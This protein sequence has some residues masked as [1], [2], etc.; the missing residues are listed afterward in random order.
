MSSGEKI[1]EGLKEAIASAAKPRIRVNARYFHAALVAVSKEETRF[2]MGGVY[3]QPHPE[4]GA[5]LVATDGHRL[6]CIHDEDAIC[7]KSAI[8]PADV[9]MRRALAE[10]GKK[11]APD[12]FVIIDEPGV[13]TIAGHYQSN[14]P[15]L[16]DGVYPKWEL[17]VLPV[18]DQ[19]KKSEPYAASTYNPEYLG[20]FKVASERLGLT[21]TPSIRIF[22]RGEA[23]PALIQFPTFPNAF[24]LLM[25]MSQGGDMDG[26]PSWMKPV[27]EPP[28]TPKKP[29]TR[30]GYCRRLR[31]EGIRVIEVEKGVGI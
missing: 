11:G 7:T 6:I 18:R 12:K 15:A 2:Y 20:A 27:L 17:V 9:S 5:L 8:V 4:K 16:I 14:G 28:A 21:S 3:I 23:G 22:P 25:P 19:F 29:K 31:R 1:V 26:L 10:G 13:I 30:L 24:A